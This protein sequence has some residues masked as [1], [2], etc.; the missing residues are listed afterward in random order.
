M[1]VMWHV[2]AAVLY[3]IILVGCG[4]LSIKKAKLLLQSFRSGSV[5]RSVGATAYRRTEPLR[6]WQLVV[7]RGVVLIGLVI[8]TCYGM[9]EGIAALI[10]LIPT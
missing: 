3:L 8:L 5:R 10:R 1:V 6:F 9:V 2:I 4:L 7:R